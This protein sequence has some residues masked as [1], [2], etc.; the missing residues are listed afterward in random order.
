[1]T[2]RD[3]IFAQHNAHVYAFWNAP[4]AQRKAWTLDQIQIIEDRIH[5]GPIYDS[6]DSYYADKDRLRALSAGLVGKRPGEYD[7]MGH[8]FGMQSN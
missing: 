3:E 7:P 5:N 1:M 2:I 8:W 6:P 4:Y